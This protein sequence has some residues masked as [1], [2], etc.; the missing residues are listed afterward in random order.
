ML[1]QRLCMLFIRVWYV[2]VFAVFTINRSVHKRALEGDGEKPPPH[3][4]EGP[5]LIC[6]FYFWFMMDVSQRPGSQKSWNST[7][8]RTF[9]IRKRLGI[10]F[11]LFSLFVWFLFCDLCLLFLLLIDNRR[12]GIG[13]SSP[14]L[15][16]MLKIVVFIIFIWFWWFLWIFTKMLCSITGC[17]LFRDSNILILLR[18][19]L[20]IEVYIN[21]HSKAT[22]KNH[23]ATKMKDPSLYFSLIFDLGWT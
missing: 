3:E 11:L 5:L 18:F 21:V 23:R 15:S 16:E 9:R 7:A 22:A 1:Y 17:M 6:V 2:D 4:N 19:L 14:G 8:S 10:Q 20:S 12:S 13:S